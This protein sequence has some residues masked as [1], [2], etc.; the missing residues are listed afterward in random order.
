VLGG[1]KSDT[2]GRDQAANGVFFIPTPENQFDGFLFL[3]RINPHMLFR[4]F[5]HRIASTE[6]CRLTSRE[7]EHTP[8]PRSPRRRDVRDPRSLGKPSLI[9]PPRP[10]ADMPAGRR[11]RD[12]RI[13]FDGDKL[14]LLCPPVRYFLDAESNRRI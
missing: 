14:F 3:K 7:H 9:T 10:I 6:Y 2:A 8:D 13:S 11:I 1:S 4:Y 12:S 5:D